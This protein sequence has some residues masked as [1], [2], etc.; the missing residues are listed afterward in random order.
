M[1]SEGVTFSS[2][3]EALLAGVHS[4]P[5]CLCPIP[6]SSN[7]VVKDEAAGELSAWFG[8]IDV[9]RTRWQTLVPV[10]SILDQQYGPKFILR[11]VAHVWEGE[12][13]WNAVRI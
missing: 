10:L 9:D 12:P 5:I 6:T 2:S 1:S 13:L 4:A 3:T 7:E 11:V 8:R